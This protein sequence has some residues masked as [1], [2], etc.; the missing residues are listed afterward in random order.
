MP[1]NCA[2]D[3][4]ALHSAP[5]WL[6][7][8]STTEYLV[9]P[10]LDFF[11]LMPL[12]GGIRQ[13]LARAREDPVDAV[14][15]EPPAKLKTHR[16][17]GRDNRAGHNVGDFLKSL[18]L[19]GR[20]SA[21]EFQEGAA[22]DANRPGCAAFSKQIAKTGTS[23]HHRYNTHRDTMTILSNQSDRPPVYDTDI[24]VWDSRLERKVEQPC[25]FLL[26]SEILD[27]EVRKTGIENWVGIR[28]NACLQ[29]TFETWCDDVEL[30]HSDPDIMALG[31][32][33]D[34]AVISPSESLFILLVNVLSGICHKRFWVCAFGKKVMCQCGC[35]G[36]HTLDSIFRVLRWDLAA[37]LCGERPSIRDDGVPFSESNRVGDKKRHRA[38]KK[39][40]K[41][42]ARA[43]VIQ[44]RGAVTPPAP[45]HPR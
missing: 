13:Q 7:P 39:N 29:S 12:Q 38:R 33:G 44:K 41:F 2:H 22:A 35:F 5:F 43:G 4:Y 36:R 23:G 11:C 20:I 40:K 15:D 34:S 17:G 24:T 42:L 10:W 25:H 8:G 9:W 18:Y 37:L 19:I 3:I 28:D 45:T 6:E 32:W 16:Y 14:A 26:P 1:D 21:P 31:I 30:N 27:Y